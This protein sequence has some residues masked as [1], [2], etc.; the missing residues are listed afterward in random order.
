MSIGF[1]QIIKMNK[2]LETNLQILHK[3]HKKEEII[4]ITYIKKAL[5][6]YIFTIQK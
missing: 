5:E 4:L 2:D 1:P 6:K 3:L